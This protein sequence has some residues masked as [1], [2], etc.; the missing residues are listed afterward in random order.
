MHS[1]NDQIAVDPATTH[2]RLTL[3]ILGLGYVGCVSA[4]CF[5][6]RGHAVIGVDADPRKTAFLAEGK[7][8]VHEERIAELTAKVVADGN[9]TVSTDPIRAVRDSDVTMVCVGTPSAPN[10]SLSTQYLETVTE[11]IGAALREKQGWHVVAY[12]STMLPGTCENLLIPILE[13]VSGKRAG[14]DFGVCVNPEFLREGSSVRDF[15]DPPKTVVGE[16]DERSG[17]LVTRLYEGLP[18]PRFRVPIRVAEMTKY[19]DN[20]FHA[21]KV[22]FANEIGA[23]CHALELDSAEL[24]DIFLADTKLNISPAYLRPGFSFGGSCLPKDVRALN[25][26]ARQHDVDVP[27]LGTLLAS[28]ETHL[29]RAVDDVVSRGHRKVGIFGLSFKTGTDDL[30]ESPMVELAERLVGKGYDVRIYDAN[31]AMSRLIGANRAFIEQRLPHLGDVLSG[32]ID[33]VIAHSETYVVGSKEPQV[34]SAIENLDDDAQ[35]LDLVRLPDAA[36]LRERSGY[37][38]IGW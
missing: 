2:H 35:I 25:Y 37:R 30:R 33:E 13:R 7:A 17:E 31:V 34:V 3:S 6:A 28:N 23:V 11:Q 26:T 19:V 4:A 27:V 36:K 14:V 29:R 9:L 12:R 15:L 16:T 21:L 10:G 20:S 24:F 32:D 38:G 22:G 5:A 1:N 18:G 8:P